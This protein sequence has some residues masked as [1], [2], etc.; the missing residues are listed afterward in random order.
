MVIYGCFRFE[1][2]I[3]G[4]ARLYA[5]IIYIWVMKMTSVSGAHYLFQSL[6]LFLSLSSYLSFFLSLSC[7]VSFCLF[8]TFLNLSHS[9]SRHFIEIEIVRTKEKSNNKNSHMT[10]PIHSIVTWPKTTNH[11]QLCKQMICDF[12]LYTICTMHIA[13]FA[14]FR[15]YT[16]KM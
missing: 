10:T 15:W 13:H 4:L 8:L 12:F 14:P 1:F 6:S 7:S 9:F 5:N 2:H 3:V 16:T 11:A